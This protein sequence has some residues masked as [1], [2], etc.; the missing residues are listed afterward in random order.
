MPILGSIA[1]GSA[2]G[3]G[4]GKGPAAIVYTLAQTFNAT[5]NYTPS[6]GTVNI[7]FFMVGA[8]GGGGE[9]RVVQDDGRTGTG[10]G[11]GGGGGQLAVKDYPVTI[12]ENWLI[13]IGAGGDPGIAGGT[14]TF[15]RTGGSAFTLA[16]ANS[17]GYGNIGPRFNDAANGGAGGGTDVHVS[18]LSYNST[19]G[20]AGA[21]S[22]TQKL[23]G[24]NGSAGFAGSTVNTISMNLGTVPVLTNF[25]VTV[26]SGGSGGGGCYADTAAAFSGGTGGTGGTNAGSGGNGGRSNSQNTIVTG[27][28]GG[29]ANSVGSAGGGGGGG[30][31]TYPNFVRGAGTYGGSGAGGRVVIYEGKFA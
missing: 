2:G 4:R 15:A 16:T 22:A 24:G 25:G 9:G 3:F 28:A 19:S 17:G 18:V 27:N 21:A 29:S 13:T 11:G 20:P 26:G 31:T 6:A 7:A 12:G 8:G 23:N 5:S 14:T 1:A 30:G 10:G